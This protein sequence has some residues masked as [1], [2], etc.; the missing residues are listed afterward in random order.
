MNIIHTDAYR[1]AF[2]EYLRRRTPIRLSLKQ[3]EVTDHYVWRT[4]RDERVRTS[5]RRNDGRIFSWASP[6]DTGHPGEDYNCR[7][8]AVAYV[9]GQTE[10]AFHDFSTSLASS[11]D[12]W[13]D[14]DF[15]R[16][17]Y[18]GAGRPVT[19]LEIGHLREIAE[20]YAY[21][22]LGDGA[23]RRLSDQIADAARK[24]GPGRLTYSFRG[25]YDFGDVQFSH[26]GG[27][28]EG[29]FSGTVE[30][31]GAMLAI[32]GESLFIFSDLFTGPLGLGIEPGGTPYEI[33]GEW[34]ASFSSDVAKDRTRSVYFWQGQQ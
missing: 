28:I 2:V 19:L 3:A 13:T 25:A 4:R 18:F 24:N 27:K 8:E 34:A 12:R 26:G 30:D 6:P 10:F 23:F 7:C 11:Y 32:S 21:D 31:R 1:S 16:H 9:E 29:G 20:Q 22:A 33:K 15:V 5:H 14:A 17:Y